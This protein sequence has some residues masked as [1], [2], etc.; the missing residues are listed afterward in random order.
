MRLDM[1]RIKKEGNKKENF[2]KQKAMCIH[3]GGVGLWWNLLTVRQL[4]ELR[5]RPT[6]SIIIRSKW[7]ERKKFTHWKYTYIRKS[8]HR[9]LVK[10]N[11][12]KEKI[13]RITGV[14]NVSKDHLT[15]ELLL[16]ARIYNN[17]WENQKQ[18][19]RMKEIYSLEVYVYQKK[20]PQNTS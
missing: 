18:M 11:I 5:W 6:E 3:D 8:Y 1:E 19:D 17:V 16:H 12:E 4:F 13:G 15:S 9:R 7:I 2:A 20:S 14:L 10:K